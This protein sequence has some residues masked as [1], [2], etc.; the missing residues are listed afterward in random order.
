MFEPDR[1]KILK[2]YMLQIAGK[3]NFKCKLRYLET[4][5]QT[6]LNIKNVPQTRNT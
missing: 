2:F 1:Q 4:L 5:T 3:C 6:H